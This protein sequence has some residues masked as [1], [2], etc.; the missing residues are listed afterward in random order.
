V[1]GESLLAMPRDG[2]ARRHPFHVLVVDNEPDALVSMRDVLE[3]EIGDVRVWTADSGPKA[4]DVLERTRVDLIFSDFRMAPMNGLEFLVLA[5][6]KAPRVPR[7]LVTAYPDMDLAIRAINE[8]DVAGLFLK[9]VEPQTV[10]D[11]VLEKL[12][13]RTREGGQARA[14]ARTMDAFRRSRTRRGP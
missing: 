11:I 14:M 12:E 13:C 1:L 5:R 8:G 3:G 7:V 6:R 9:P 4:L 10:V 2:A